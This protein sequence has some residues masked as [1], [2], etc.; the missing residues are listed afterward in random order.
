MLKKIFA[1]IVVSSICV[2]VFASDLFPEGN[3]RDIKA[4]DFVLQTDTVG[5]YPIIQNDGNW[6]FVSGNAYLSS[7][8]SDPVK[9]GYVQLNYYAGGYLLARQNISVNTGAGNNLSWGGSPCSP[10]HLF[11]RN[12]GRGRQDNCMTIDAQ[13]VTSGTSFTTFLSVV[14]TNSG[15]S[16]RYYRIIF[17]INADVLGIRGTGVGDWTEDELK[18]KP[19]KKEATDRL[20]AWAEKVQDGSIKAFDFSKPQDV[21]AEVPSF[22]TLLPVPENL[23]G[24]K[25]AISFVSAVEHL[26]HVETIKSIA[27]ARYGDYKGTWGFVTNQPSQDAADA[28]AVAKCE[29]IRS[30]NRPDVPACSVYRITDGARVSDTYDFKKASQK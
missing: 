15:G 10:G 30:I 21:Y 11:I 8:G 24:E 14:L 4:G 13:S 20:A 18:A 2:H 25:R 9:M 12:K 16:G 3:L 27:Y 28:A 29:S 26:R 5:G 1:A 17:S 22:M 7:G 23:V 19:Y 6:E